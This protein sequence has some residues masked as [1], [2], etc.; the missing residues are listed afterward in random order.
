MRGEFQS[1]VYPYL[2]S[3]SGARQTNHKAERKRTKMKLVGKKTVGW[4]KT[5]HS[6]KC[7]S[8]C[9]PHS[10]RA[11]SSSVENRLCL[12]KSDHSSRLQNDSGLLLTDPIKHV[13]R[14][15]PVFEQLRRTPS[16]FRRPLAAPVDE[17]LGRRREPVWNGRKSPSSRDE[18]DD[19]TGVVHVVSGPRHAA[20]IE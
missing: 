9:N 3:T 4:K 19:L 17:I 12:H 20:S 18:Q 2:H 8:F 10:L 1:F 6:M 13:H 5:K 14:D 11:H 15:P 16:F 7:H